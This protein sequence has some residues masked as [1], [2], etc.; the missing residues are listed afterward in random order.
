MSPRPGRSK[1]PIFMVLAAL[2]A[3]LLILCVPTGVLEM[4]VASTGISETLPAAAPPLG[5]KARGLLALFAAVMGGGLAGIFVRP[6]AKKDQELRVVRAKGARKMGFAFS[7]LTALARGR[8]AVT[9]PDDVPTQR[10]ADA[11]P[12]APPR[13]PIFASRD[14][15]GLEIFGRPGD[16]RRPLPLAQDDADHMLPASPAFAAP[17]NARANV[18]ADDHMPTFMREPHEPAIIFLPEE[19]PRMPAAPVRI[20]DDAPDVMPTPQFAA[21][22]PPAAA[23]VAP[24]S[25]SEPA[26]VPEPS[27]E[28][29]PAPLPLPTRLPTQGL[30]VAELTARLERGLAQRTRA[31]VP[32]VAGHGVIADMPV[33][34]AVPVR[35]DV[36]ADTDAALRAALGALR[37]LT[38]RT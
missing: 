4:V 9:G 1:G 24:P 37:S 3:A 12:D 16:G 8:G 30:S 38:G 15:D 6:P 31:T 36:A 23:P 33:A 32:P 27:I 14:F 35:T 20:F 21:P 29:A 7:K 2:A 25:A 5:F 26:P 13:P 34:N 11:H 22:P 28:P 17:A 18:D 10:R 19:E